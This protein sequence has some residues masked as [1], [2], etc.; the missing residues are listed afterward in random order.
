MVILKA[1]HPDIESFIDWKVIEEQKVAALVSGSRTC[2]RRLQA[3]LDAT[4]VRGSAVTSGQ[5]GFA[6]DD[7][8]IE[9]VVDPARNAGL[10][11]ALRAARSAYVPEAYIQRTLQM[12]AQGLTDLDFREYDTDWDGAAYG[13]VSGQNSN[14]SVRLP[15]DF[16]DALDANADWE[17]IPPHRRQGRAQRAGAARCGTRSPTPRGRAPIPAC[18]TTPRSTSGTPARRTGASTPRTRAS[19]ATPWWRRRSAGGASTRSWRPERGRRRRR[20][21]ARIGTGVRHR[22]QARVPPAHARRLLAQADRRPQGA[23]QEPRRR[24]GAD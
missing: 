10:K 22:L 17:L 3:I 1:D 9:V 14:N 13:T 8:D 11:N 16:F 15:N 21:D 7:A 24:R 23:D 18:S 4:Q 20:Q 6:L 19:P 2:Q 5:P 12:A